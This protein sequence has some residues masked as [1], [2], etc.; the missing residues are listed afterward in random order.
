MV[1]C[2]QNLQGFSWVAKLKDAVRLQ[3]RRC[4]PVFGSLEGSPPGRAVFPGMV[5]VHRGTQKVKK[6]E[7]E[8]DW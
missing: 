7:M 8:H 5:R 4:Q 6:M 1:R 2:D 3:I